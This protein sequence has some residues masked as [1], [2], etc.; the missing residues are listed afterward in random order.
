[1][2]DLL[3]PAAPTYQCIA[4]RAA[5]WAVSPSCNVVRALLHNGIRI[6]S[7]VFKY[8]RRDDIVRF[9]YSNAH[10][11]LIPWPVDEEDISRRNDAGKLVEVPI[12]S[13]RRWLGAFLTRGRLYRVR[14]T[15]THPVA[16]GSRHSRASSPLPSLG[17]KL[18]NKLS[19]LTR[20][21]A[22]KADFNQCTGRQLIAALNR[23]SRYY[24]YAGRELPFVLIGHSKQFTR[25]GERSLR[26]FLKEVRRDKEHYRF[27]NLSGAAGYWLN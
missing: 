12:Y 19:M 24:A 20:C 21:H 16:N 27:A 10:N 2:E 4:F 5:N 22:W 13:E 9:D 1:L 26:W 8:G 18:L 3:K 23:A 17:K 14:M 11:N 25:D 15:R 7:S 6:E